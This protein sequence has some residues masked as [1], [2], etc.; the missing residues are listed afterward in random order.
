ML[1]RQLLHCAELHGFEV[2]VLHFVE[3]L[4]GRGQHL[5]FAV[6][7][8]GEK[9]VLQVSE[10]L[11]V[12]L[13]LNYER[14]I[15]VVDGLVQHV[16]IEH[17]KLGVIVFKLLNGV[18]I[19]AQVSVL[20][21]A[22]NAAVGNV[23]VQIDVLDVFLES[24]GHILFTLLPHGGES[25]AIVVVELLHGALESLGALENLIDL[26]FGLDVEYLLN[27]VGG[28]LIDSFEQVNLLLFHHLDHWCQF[29][30]ISILQLI[31]KSISSVFK[32]GQILNLLLTQQV[33]HS[34]SNTIFGNA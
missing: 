5:T 25:V 31:F 16:V 17:T 6:V 15:L 20:D 9:L 21:D 34:S 29:L 2:L 12:G 27:I 7:Q 1:S 23:S 19:L 32:V 10:C 4:Q 18:C 14:V 33:S 11:I 30:N 28:G 8:S 24:A 3:D 22:I 13:C 26:V